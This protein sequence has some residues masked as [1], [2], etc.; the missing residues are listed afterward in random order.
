MDTNQIYERLNILF[1]K[2]KCS[3]AVMACDELA[4]YSIK[5]YPAALVVNN[6]PAKQKGE[7]WVGLFVP[8]RNSPVTFFCSYG[9]DIE[10]YSHHFSNFV[11]KN[12]FVQI[13]KRLQDFKSSTCGHY[14]IYFLYKLMKGCKLQ[15]IYRRFSNNYKRNDFIVSRFVK[16]LYK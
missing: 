13:K 4:S 16:N 9:L 3:F 6:Q 11:K 8:K 2:R 5:S 10:S 12:G 7:H 14:C 15:I 1:A